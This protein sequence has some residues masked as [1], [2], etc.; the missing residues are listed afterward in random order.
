MLSEVTEDCTFYGYKDV[1]GDVVS[2][3]C[4]YPDNSA[5]YCDSTKYAVE[6]GILDIFKKFNLNCTIVCDN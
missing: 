6:D 5:R 3:L 1:N 2:C 4:V